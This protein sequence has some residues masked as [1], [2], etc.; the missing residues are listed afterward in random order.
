MRSL[1]KNKANI[2]NSTV[3]IIGWAIEKIAALFFT[4]LVELE[5]H[6]GDIIYLYIYK[7]T[8]C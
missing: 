4:L 8:S 1:Q 2:I 7:G 6:I 5:K 3:N